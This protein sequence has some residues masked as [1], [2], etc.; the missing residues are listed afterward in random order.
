LP[1]LKN[2][3]DGVKPAFPREM[4]DKPAVKSVTIAFL[5]YVNSLTLQAADKSLFIAEIERHRAKWCINEI[6]TP[7]TDH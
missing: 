6:D 2:I 4:P 5:E 1:A 7:S 3:R